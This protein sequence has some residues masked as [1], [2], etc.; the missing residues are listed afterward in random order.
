MKVIS[1][2]LPRPTALPRVA[3]LRNSTTMVGSAGGR[4]RA[5]VRRAAASRLLS[6][7]AAASLGA[8]RPRLDAGVALIPHPS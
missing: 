1:I 7:A 4:S 8:R 2:A 6:T 3:A 5:L